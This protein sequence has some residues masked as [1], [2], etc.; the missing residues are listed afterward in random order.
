M[1]L[2][3]WPTTMWAGPISAQPK[4]KKRGGVVGLPVGLTQ[5]SW[6]GLVAARLIWLG[7]V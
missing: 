3:G 6:I 7:R 4:P 5:L 2:L 1:W